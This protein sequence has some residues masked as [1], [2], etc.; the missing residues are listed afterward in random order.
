MKLVVEMLIVAQPDKNPWHFLKPSSSLPCSH[1]PPT[2]SYPEPGESSPHLTI[3]LLEDSLQYFM[4]K[5]L[6]VGILFFFFLFRLF[7]HFRNAEKCRK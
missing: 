6:H 4:T 2:G 3:L 1:D 7:Y 5:D